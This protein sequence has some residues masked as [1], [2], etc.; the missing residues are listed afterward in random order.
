MIITIHYSIHCAITIILNNHLMCICAA[1][2]AEM[3]LVFAACPP[4]LHRSV[5]APT[6]CHLAFRED[7]QSPMRIIPK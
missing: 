1:Y 3:T 5:L 6:S 2:L 7:Y 4:Q